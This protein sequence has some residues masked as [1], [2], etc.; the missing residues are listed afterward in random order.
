MNR[1]TIE[2]IS[3][4]STI[5]SILGFFILCYII[6]FQKIE[7]KLDCD[8]TDRSAID[9][10]MK[11]LDNCYLTL[12]NLISIKTFNNSSNPETNV[13]TFI[14]SVSKPFIIELL[15]NFTDDCLC[16]PNKYN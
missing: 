14:Y 1:K 8:S 16:C 2:T 11:A 12:H 4:I 5:T 6:T 13:K 9:F 7:I 10:E 3:L 15:N